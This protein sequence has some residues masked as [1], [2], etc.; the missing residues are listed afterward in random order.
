MYPLKVCQYTLS[1]H[2]SFLISLSC[3]TFSS[4]S[5]IKNKFFPSGDNGPWIGFDCLF[6]CVPLYFVC[7][8]V[9]LFTL[10]VGLCSCLLCLFGC[11][12]VYF[13][14]LSVFLFSL[15]TCLCSCLVMCWHFGFSA[16]TSGIHASPRILVLY[17]HWVN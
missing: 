11:V 10:F 12:P 16:L 4:F 17:L 7:W 9:F 1:S 13:V 8:S 3:S 15:F 2:L 14:C 5:F 6:V